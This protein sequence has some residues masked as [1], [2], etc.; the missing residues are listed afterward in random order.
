[1]YLKF[2][3]LEAFCIFGNNQLIDAALDITVHEGGEIVDGVIDAMVGDSTLR[4]VV[5]SNFCGAIAGRDESFT[6]RSDVIDVF[7][8]L[9]VVNEGAQ[10]SQSALFVLR[11]VA[12]FG[13]FDEDFLRLRRYW[14]SS[15]YNED[16]RRTLLY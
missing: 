9:F 1:M 14:G 13:T 7:L 3:L 11:L 6:A 2:T 5:C 4:I 16:A 10:T 8:V 12:R 15:N